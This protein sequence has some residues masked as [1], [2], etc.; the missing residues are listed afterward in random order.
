MVKIE[1]EQNESIPINNFLLTLF[2]N[3]ISLLRNL[4][5]T[6]SFVKK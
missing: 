3:I 1:L 6:I 4:N 5:Q 2:L